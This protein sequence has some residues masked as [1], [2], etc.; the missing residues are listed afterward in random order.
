[1]SKLKFVKTLT[2]HVYGGTFFFHIYEDA[3]QIHVF[4][5]GDKISTGKS[6][7]SDKSDLIVNDLIGT[8]LARGNCPAGSFEKPF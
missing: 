7:S 1:M 4:G 2:R 3:R 5:S 8:L 6:E